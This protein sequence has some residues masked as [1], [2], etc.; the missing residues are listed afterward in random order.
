VTASACDR[1]RIDAISSYDDAWAEVDDAK[2][3]ALLKAIWAND[4]VYVD[5]DIPEGVRGP[6]ALSDFI[7]VT[8]SEMPGLAIVTT[9]PV[10][11]LSDRAFYGWACTWGEGESLEGIDFVEFGS[12]GRIERLTNFYPA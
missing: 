4:G 10:V 5:P 9:R 12:D 3:L 1:S 6:D 2:R 8:Q 11:V 7:A